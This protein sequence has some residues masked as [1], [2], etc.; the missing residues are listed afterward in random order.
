MKI[1]ISFKKHPREKGL[2]RVAQQVAYDVK[3]NK[4]KCGIIAKRAPHMEGSDFSIQISIKKNSD[5]TDS[6]SNCDWLWIF[7]KNDCKTE[8][9]AKAVISDM[10]KVVS[11][12]YTLHYFDE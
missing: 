5:F 2:R 7:I 3:V 6:G 9:E 8:D 11:Q 4:K 12:K 1:N 10:L